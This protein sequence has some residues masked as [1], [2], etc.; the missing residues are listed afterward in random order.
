MQHGGLDNTDYWT[1]S[2]LVS[3]VT[4]LLHTAVQKQQRIYRVCGERHVI[5]IIIIKRNI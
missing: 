3:K 4:Q 5:I 2:G 1:V